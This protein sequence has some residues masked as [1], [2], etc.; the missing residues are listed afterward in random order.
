MPEGILI[1]YNDGR[2]VMAITA[3]LRAPSYCGATSGQHGVGEGTGYDVPVTMT[4]GSELITISTRPVKIQ[5]FTNPP[6][7]YYMSSITRNGN[8]SVTI[9]FDK[10]GYRNGEFVDFD[11]TFL[12]ILPAVTYN[13]G[14][15]ISNS[16]D[17]TAISN[18]SR[19]MTCAYSGR[20]TVNGSAPLPVS[21]IPFGK[22]DNPN[23]SVGFDGGNIIVRDISYT[24]RD[25]LEGTVSIELAIFNLTAPVA[26]DGITMTN[27][28]GQV[29]FSTQKRPLVYDRTIQISDSLQNI[30]GGYCH[31]TCTGTQVRMIGGYANVRTKGIVMSGGSIRSA[32]NRVFGNY[33]VSGWDATFNKNIWMPL[34]ILPPM[35]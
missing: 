22:W 3:G 2:P 17:F 4:D 26:G 11:A 8:S 35:Y 18:Q 21:G 7:I 20:I 9:N 14:L 13:E 24:G 29:T 34:L 28:A 32:Y 10:K 19:L 33:F 12:E 16:T 31:L 1:D 23:V 5:N 30:G 27:A 6:N 15:F 25:D